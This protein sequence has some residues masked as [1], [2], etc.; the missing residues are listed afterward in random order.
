MSAALH[1]VF[2]VAGA[3]YVL[4]ADEVLHMDA[5]A[6]ATPVPGTAAHVLGLVQVR[7]QVVPVIDLRRRFGLPVAE[8]PE[9]ARVIVVRQ[10]DRVVGLLA[11]SA[12]EVMKLDPEAFKKPPELVTEQAQGY[13]KSVIQTGGRLLMRV[14]L[15]KIV[16]N[17]SF[18]T[19][20][21]EER[22]DGHQG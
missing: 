14:D 7:G 1:V 17:E 10:N 8:A 22:T 12:R 6:G 19:T 11:E 3:D 20:P 5:Y 15:D 4:P 18:Q 2:K 21:T 13:V 16:G 9:G